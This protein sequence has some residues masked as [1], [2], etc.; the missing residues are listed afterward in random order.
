MHAVIQSSVLAE[1]FCHMLFCDIKSFL[2][3]LYYGIL[4]KKF[5]Y[6]VTVLSRVETS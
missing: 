3:L 5:K 4:M 6:N 1:V 2:P